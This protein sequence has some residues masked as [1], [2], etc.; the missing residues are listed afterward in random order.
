MTDVLIVA[1][2]ALSTFA[3]VWGTIIYP[4]AKEKKKLEA[5]EE[6]KQAER[7]QDIDGLNTVSGEVVI[8]RLAVR[9]KAVETEMRKVTAGQSLLEKRMDEA[10]GT[11]RATR[12]TVEE[13]RTLVL[14][15]AS[16]NI[17]TKDDL[18]IAAKKVAAEAV[19]RQVEVLQAL[20]EHAEP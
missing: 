19:G 6:K 5:E 1:L 15:L 14:G 10:N 9:V 18:N 12:E 7:D 20:A 4:R 3:A 17:A 16:T 13:I 11:G 2:T 8:P